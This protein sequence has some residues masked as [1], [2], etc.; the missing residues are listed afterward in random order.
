MLA[1]N[2]AFG[3]RDTVHSA[4]FYNAAYLAAYQR[5]AAYL[6]RAHKIMNGVNGRKQ[7]DVAAAAA[8]VTAPTHYCI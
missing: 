1:F 3:A 4:R 8:Y 7:A 6:V 5:R 2:M